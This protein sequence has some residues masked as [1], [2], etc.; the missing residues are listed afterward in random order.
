MPHSARILALT[1]ALAS[2]LL[3]QLPPL[4]DRELFFGDPEITGAQISPNGKL[5]S[6]VKPYKGVRNVWVK[7]LAEPFDQA[8]PV[9]AHPKRPIP[10]YFWSR[11]A[12]FILFVQDND[13]DE[14]FNLFAVDP[15][16]KP[17]A[18]KDVP[19]PRNL[20]N[21]KGVATQIVDVPRHDPNTVYL[22]INDRDK[23]WHDLYRVNLTTGEKTLVRKNTDRIVGWEFDLAGQLR[24][25]LRSNDAGDTE[26]MRVDAGKFT[27]IYDCNALEACATVRFHK[28]GKRVY[29]QS[30]KGD[31]DLISLMLLDV[32][33]GKTELVETDPLKKVDFGGAVFSD[34]SNELVATSYTGDRRRLYFK[35]KKF[36]ADYKWLQSKLPNKE[37][38]FGAHTNDENLWVINASSDNEPGETYIF[39][40]TA[41]TLDLQYKV[42]EKLPRPALAS[43]ESI[44]YQSSDGLEIPAYLTLPKGVP[45]KNLPLVVVP[46]GGP[47]GRD[48]W[49]YNG[50]AQFLANRGYAVLQP[51]FRSSVGFGK[52]FLD[53]GNGKWGET[54]QDDITW[55]VKHLIGNGMVDPKRVGIMGGSYGGYATLA[56]VAFT[57]D[58]YQAGVAIVAPSNLLTLLDSIPPYWESFRKT[59]YL[60]MADP[61]T[62]EGKEKLKKQSPLYSADKIKT[63]L[64]VVQGANDPRVNQAESDQIVIALR[65]RG[66][67]V[68]YLVA[69]DEGHGFARPINNMAMF[70]A[71]EKFLAKHLG[72][73]AQTDAKPEVEARLKEIMVDPKTVKLAPKVSTTGAAAPVPVA[74]LQAGEEKWVAKIALGERQM[75]LK[76]ATR[77]E[78][79]ADAFVVTD[80]TSM[81]QGEMKEAATL[82]KKSLTLKKRAIQQ[83]PMTINADYDAQ[84]VTGSMVMG[85]QNRPLDAKLDGPLF[86]D[87]A[88][89]YQSVAALPLAP[90][91]SAM[92]RNF[93]LQSQKVKV[94]QLKVTG[95]EKVSVPAG[96]F[97][98]FKVELTPAEGGA[99]KTTVWVAK[100]PR[101]AVKVSSV[102]PQLNGAVMTAELQ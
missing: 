13:G 12:K 7:A 23:A 79:T 76:I 86:A 93:D 15:L 99:Q 82:D 71:A 50:F 92:F 57:P 72:G 85:G 36:E 62:P 44:R 55:G 100:A 25:A 3:A 70:L 48:V 28:D 87:S 77:I 90:G 53:L 38:N 63:P 4:I 78:E 60:R 74:G 56:G 81:P 17:A 61:N 29:L 19:D 91:Y 45:A 49:G 83:G 21:A 32:A 65:D 95:E 43:V 51:N 97:D 75:E 24:L 58:V 37:V 73:R 64:L 88:G 18:G 68:E 98:A 52:K 84:K 33:T 66:F 35:D 26:I 67:P 8:R 89:S 31:N 27:K 14:N 5:V 1:A 47:W 46:H 6:F 101:R 80:T 10:Q 40:R 69:P 2:G 42:R 9:T 54:M 59:M 102:M 11:D 20:T 34:V 96:T 22:G 94:M 41:K 16:A 30:N 39:N